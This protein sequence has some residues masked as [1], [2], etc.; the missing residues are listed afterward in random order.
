MY[1]IYIIRIPGDKKKKWSRI[2][3]LGNNSWGPSKSNDDIP[4]TSLVQRMPSQL[5]TKNNTKHQQT[6]Q[7]DTYT[8]I[9][10][11]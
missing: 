1:K 8:Y 3:I 7:T 6:I 9:S 5:N 4:Q 2:N 10:Q 11:V